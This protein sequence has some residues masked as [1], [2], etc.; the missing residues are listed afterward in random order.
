MQSGTARTDCWLLEFDASEAKKID[1]L[2]GWTGC[3]NTQSQVRL[4]FE[5]KENAIA[6]AE[7]H[8]LVYSVTENL[9]RKPILR[10]NGYGDNFATN[11]KTSWTH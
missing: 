3:N 2:M 10:K 4:A 5:N 11:R 8:G 6:Y 1:P 7:K 9:V